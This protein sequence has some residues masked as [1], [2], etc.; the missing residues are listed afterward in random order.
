MEIAANEYPAD[1]YNIYGLHATDGYNFEPPYM[2]AG[3]IERMVTPGA[4]N[5]NYFGYLEIDPSGYGYG[6]TA[7]MASINALSDAAR[8]R[9]G[10][11]IVHSQDEVPDAMRE[12]LAKDATSQ[13]GS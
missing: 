10:A 11:A 3:V 7:G 13:G 9:V 5:F 12:I 1:V 4:G 6:T 2:L 8:A